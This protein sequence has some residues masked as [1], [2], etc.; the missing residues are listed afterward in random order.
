[1]ATRA[2]VGRLLVDAG[3]LAERDV[4]EVVAAAGRKGGRFCSVALRLGLADERALVRVLSRQLGVPGMVVGEVQPDAGGRALVP[5]ETA[6]RLAVLPVRAFN[7]TLTLL[8]RDPTDRQAL[9]DLQ[10]LTGKVVRPLVALEGPLR[11]AIASFYSAEPAEPAAAPSGSAPLPTVAPDVPV[12]PL[13]PEALLPAFALDDDPAIT[14]PDAGET[15]PD[16]AARDD[17][18]IVLLAVDDDPAI[19]KLYEG[20]FDPTGWRLVTCADGGRALEVLR[21]VHPDAVLLDALLPGVHGFDICRRIK[22]SEALRQ[23][24]VILLSA[25]YRGWQMRADLMARY[26][27]D[28]FIE[29]PFGVD[30]LV[31]RIRELVDAARAGAVGRRTRPLPADALRHLNSGLVLLQKGQLDAAAEAFR[32]SVRAD[33]FAARPHFYLGKIYERRGEPF[34]AMYEYE[35]AVALDGTFFP[36][37]KDLAVLYQNHGF[38]QKAIETWQQALAACPEPSMRKA[39]K[40][41]L[42]RLL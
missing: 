41:H 15:A 25:G 33:P 16:D 36:A 20:I 13:P 1:M 6:E 12:S 17:E 10:F 31:R 7:R 9:A 37:I 39:I 3:V 34:E 42:V 32:Q 23:V 14:E 24:V 5:R 40:E 4:D 26:G 28:E 30:V 21:E 19:L 8:M 18:R 22:Q 2:P 27:A 38:V 29:K 11:E 35:Q